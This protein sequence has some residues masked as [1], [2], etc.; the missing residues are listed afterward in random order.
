VA[1]QLQRLSP[2]GREL[3]TLIAAGGRV[4]LSVLRGFAELAADQFSALP[5]DSVWPL[6][7]AFLGD[8]CLTVRDSQAAEVLFDELEPFAGFTLD[9]GFTTNAGPADRYRAAMAQLCGWADVA[10]E[11]ITGAADFAEASGSPVWRTHVEQTWSWIAGEQGD[12]VGARDHLA[13]AQRLADEYGLRRSVDDLAPIS[14][15]QS[16][17][18]TASMPLPNGISGREAEVLALL[19]VGY[20]NQSIADAL[21]ISP[22]TAANHVRSILRK[23]D[24]ANRTE[25]AGFAI[26]HGLVPPESTAPPT[27]GSNGSTSAL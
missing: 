4:Q 23:T 18:A 25:A 17:S 21:F 13:S 15:D 19:A 14:S 9:A 6:A 5:R 16:L 7:L 3:T 12:Q 2:A 20:T 24:S 10:N 8:V 1:G 11:L 26:H 27:S 22:N